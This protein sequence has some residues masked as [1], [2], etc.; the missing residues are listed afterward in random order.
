MLSRSEIRNAIELGE[1]QF[2]GMVRRSHLLLRLGPHLCPFRSESQVIDPYDPESVR[3]CYAE[4]IEEWSTYELAPGE[5]VLCSASEEI[6]FNG[7][8]GGLISGLSHVA[9][10]GLFVHCGSN[11]VDP[12]FDGNLT[13]ELLNV[14]PHA[15]CLHRRMPVAKVV[16]VK[17]FHENKTG[18]IDHRIRYGR[19]QRIKSAYAD[20]FNKK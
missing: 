4:E 5:L 11:V 6:K 8:Y 13:F 7:N 19:P 20:E 18:P 9:R 14:S 17:W 15:L 12:E 3:D 16:V 1:I 10:L 2:E